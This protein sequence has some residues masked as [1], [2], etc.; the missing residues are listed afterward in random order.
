MS[1]AIIRIMKTGKSYEIVVKKKSRT[2]RRENKAKEN[3]WREIH[4]DEKCFSCA[5]PFTTNVDVSGFV[6][7]VYFLS[8][9]SIFMTWPKFEIGL[10]KNS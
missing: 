8:A 4:A 10:N 7:C 2:T 9:A 1:K 6:C 5:L 3:V